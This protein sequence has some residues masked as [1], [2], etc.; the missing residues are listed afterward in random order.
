MHDAPI[1]GQTRGAK[2]VQ[3]VDVAI[4]KRLFDSTVISVDVVNFDAIPDAVYPVN[5]V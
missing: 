1:T 4:S 2:R 5:T 3:N